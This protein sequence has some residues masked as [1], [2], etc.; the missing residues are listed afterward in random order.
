MSMSR[1]DAK[2]IKELPVLMGE[3]DVIKSV[4]MM[5][6][7][8]S[9]GELSS[10]F[11]VRGGNSDQNLILLDGAPILRTPAIYFGFFSMLNPDAVSDVILF[12]G[13]L[14]ASYGG[15]CLLR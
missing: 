2:V 5:P 4:V 11:N 15:T 7:I 1:V 14:P 9:V 8:Q 6:G 10:G 13:G 3:A 12:K